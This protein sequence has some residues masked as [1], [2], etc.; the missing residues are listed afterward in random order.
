MSKPFLALPAVFLAA[1]LTATVAAVAAR[2]PNVVV[3]LADDA[4]WG[5][6]SFNGNTNVATPSIDRI[7]REGVVF[8]RFYVCSVCVPTRAE[9]AHLAGERRV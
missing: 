8:D 1:F 4:A 7:A 3:L 9:F 6:F 2:P 5:D